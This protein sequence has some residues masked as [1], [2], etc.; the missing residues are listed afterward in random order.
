M[1]AAGGG[2]AAGGSTR[3]TR[4]GGAGVDWV[5]V[6]RG[7]TRPTRTGGAGGDW[8]RGGSIRPTR[9]GRGSSV[10][11]GGGGGE[12]SRVVVG[13]GAGEAGGVGAVWGIGRGAGAEDRC[14]DGDLRLEPSLLAGAGRSGDNSPFAGGGVTSGGVTTGGEIGDSVPALTCTCTGAD[15]A[16]LTHRTKNAAVAA[17]KAGA[18][19]RRTGLDGEFDAGDGCDVVIISPVPGESAPDH[20]ELR[21]QA[22]A[23]D[24]PRVPCPP[25]SGP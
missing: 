16:P 23:G 8:G 10:P 25:A 14:G 12:G 9:A 3:P 1:G 15:A 19:K 4:T 20:C 6:G 18:R 24:R 17:A 7:A 11:A 5:G 2:G 21:A 13:W 22:Q